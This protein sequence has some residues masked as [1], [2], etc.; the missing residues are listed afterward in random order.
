MQMKFTLDPKDH[1]F[2]MRHFSLVSNAAVAINAAKQQVPSMSTTATITARPPSEVVAA[3][4][5]Y[6]EKLMIVKICFA[7]CVCKCVFIRWEI[8]IKFWCYQAQVNIRVYNVLTRLRLENEDFTC[9]PLHRVYVFM[10][11]LIKFILCTLQFRFFL[12]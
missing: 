5:Q 2:H 11:C 6:M 8:Y 1:K 9:M 12:S 10:E 7:V 4:M 3:V